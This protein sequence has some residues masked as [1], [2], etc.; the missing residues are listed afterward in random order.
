MTKK[1]K[2]LAVAFFKIKRS[3][4]LF[5]KLGA[6]RALDR[7]SECIDVIREAVKKNRG[8]EIKTITGDSVM[9]TFPT[10]DCA[11]QAAIS[12]QE[13][14]IHTDLGELSDGDAVLPVGIG[15]AFGDVLVES[16]DVYGHT[17]H[18]AAR[19][20]AE[21]KGGQ[22]LTSRETTALLTSELQAKTRHVDRMPAKGISKPIDVF[23]VV[24]ESEDVTRV[25]SRALHIT[26]RADSLLLKY[27]ETELRLDHSSE[28]I[29]LGR[30]DDV[31]L[32]VVEEDASRH[33][34]QIEPRRGKFVLMDNSV[35]G[36]YVETPRGLVCLR[37]KETMALNDSGRIALGCDFDSASEIVYF[38]CT[39]AGE[40]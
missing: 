25:T 29:V 28:P 36:T 16:G 8:K 12:V 4:N 37:N 5:E 10:A 13:S 15:F 33:H 3:R 24:W 20:A 14:I 17:V 23:D 19:V 18:I 27:R 7:V 6:D 1:K 40:S 38:E 2:S 31:D 22:V 11:T 21:A 34:L 35:N 30:G 32:Q 39:L 26:P 9:C